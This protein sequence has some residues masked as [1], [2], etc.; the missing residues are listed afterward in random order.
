MSDE[1]VTVTVK[2]LDRE[3]LVGCKPSE[4]EG[5][6]RAVEHLNQKMREIRHASRSP[7]YDRIAVLAALDI[8]HELLTLRR[9]QSALSDSAGEHIAMLRRK[10]EDALEA[11]LE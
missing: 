3:F 10:L 5:L 9:N 6:L 11:P 7:G 8:T 1:S 4:R 2:L